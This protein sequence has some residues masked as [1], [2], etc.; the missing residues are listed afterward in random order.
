MTQGMSYGNEYPSQRTNRHPAL[1]FAPALLAVAALGCTGQGASAVESARDAGAVDSADDTSL[2]VVGRDGGEAG[3]PDGSGE[4]SVPDA[5]ACPTGELSCGG[6]CVPSDVHHCGACAHDCSALPHVSGSVSCGASGECTFDSASCADGWAH[7]SSNA[8]DGCETDV[9]TPAHCGSCSTTCLSTDPVCAASSAGRVCATG[10]PQATPTLCGG[11]CVDTTD[12]AK[13][14]DGCGHACPG[15]VANA[16][17][18]C[19][20]ST[21]TF[22]CNSG[23]SGCPAASPTAC[24]DQQLDPNNCGSCGHTCLGP[25]AG[26]GQPACSGGTC[27]LSC[28]AGLTACPTAA[29]TE[30]A[31]TTADTSN[32]GA[33]GQACTTNVVNAHATCGGQSCGFACNAG[34]L[35]C[36]GDAC[37]PEAD[38]VNGAFVS[39]AGSGTTCT[40]TQPCT[41]IAAA[42]ATKRPVIYLDKGT[43]D[44]S[45][46]LPA[47]NLTIH[48]GWTFAAGAWT[49]CGGTS[50]TSIIA[51]PALVG[52]NAAVGSGPNSG[53]WTLDTLTIEDDAAASGGASL[54]G[55]F[56]YAG[57]L[58]LQNVVVVVGDGGDGAPETL[59]VPNGTAGAAAGS[60]TGPASD[61]LPGTPGSPGAG[62][63][64]TGYGVEGSS[65]FG[66]GG[67]TGS[68]GDNGK[69]ATAGGVFGCGGGG[70]Y[71]GRGGNGGG[72]SVGI[73]VTLTGTVTFTGTSVTAGKGGRGGDGQAGGTGGPGTSAAGGNGGSG[74]NGG[75]GGGGAGGDSLCF[76][77]GQGGTVT[78]TPTCAPGQGGLGGDQGL[79]NTGAAGRS[80]LHN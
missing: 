13:N 62:G 56:L 12:D 9:T 2:T 31:D 18:T 4:A 39:P 57:A 24:V 64:R 68:I 60:C 26:A 15:G 19:S 42:L 27:T 41:T 37:I 79:S 52:T 7:C 10:C 59:P 50:G 65:G 23:Y 80:A 40:A 74:G 33:C 44:E 36:N 71:G 22:T 11:S 38:T 43:Y 6:S 16:Q 8:D 63:V 61:G 70:A 69:A 17:P 5:A 67:G 45:V 76:V 66:G 49:N 46:G 25:T 51:A 34:Y 48:G 54:Y 73:L 20:A 78:G 29:P 35:V 21:C 75:V 1:V 3:V 30:C 58:T 55:V 53:T 32:C 77:T 28:G 14:C 72:S 47:A